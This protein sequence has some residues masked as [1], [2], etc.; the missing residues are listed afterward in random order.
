M[1]AKKKHGKGRKQSNRNSPKPQKRNSPK[2][3]NSNSSN[4]E[5]SEV[6]FTPYDVC[7]TVKHARSD[8]KLS[9]ESY[10]QLLL[11]RMSLSGL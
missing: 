10:G 2:A 8:A 4:P 11:E 3:K 1:M 6:Q 5:T 9:C 7:K